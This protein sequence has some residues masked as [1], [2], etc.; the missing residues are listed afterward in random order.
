M[1]I[2]LLGTLKQL[3]SAYSVSE[4]YRFTAAIPDCQALG[5]LDSKSLSCWMVS[6]ASLEKFLS[7]LI[8]GLIQVIT[9]TSQADDQRG[10]LLIARCGIG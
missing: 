8:Y 4:R 1:S 3:F 9:E 6:W 2:V 7:M 5:T 10:D